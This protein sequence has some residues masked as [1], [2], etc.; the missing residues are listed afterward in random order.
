[1]AQILVRNLDDGVAERLKTRAQKAGKSLEQS[2]R[3]I[4]TEAAKP[5]R[6]DVWAEIDRLRA[7]AGRVTPGAEVLIREDRD[8]R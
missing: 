1:M 7:E 3:E 6:E 2:I 8:S 5:S 4:L